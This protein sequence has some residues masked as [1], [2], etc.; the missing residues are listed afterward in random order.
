MTDAE[1]IARLPV[2]VEAPF[3]VCRL[4]V[5]EVHRFG[6][7]V[8][9]RHLSHGFA[10]LIGVSIDSERPIV[11][12]GDDDR[13][14]ARAITGEKPYAVLGMH[15]TSPVVGPG[16]SMVRKDWV[17]T[18]WLRLARHLRDRMGL[19]V[20]AAG[21]ATEQAVPSR[22][23]RNL[24]GLPIKVVGALMEQA[25]CTITVESGLAHLGHAV[26][27]PMVV[28]FS[29]DVPLEWASPSEASRCRV[30][31]ETPRFVTPDDVVAAIHTVLDTK[32]EREMSLAHTR[33]RK[34]TAPRCCGSGRRMRP[35]RA[36]ST[37]STRTRSCASAA[38]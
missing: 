33:Y 26:D 24:Y 23:W 38:M 5:H 16:W 30:L 31:Y 8:F 34:A 17:F 14:A 7:D 11:A 4:D 22:Y 32:L 2:G 19:E 3:R 15:S 10:R 18:R 35:P 21:G 36:S 27:A 29:R 37:T 6:P 20:L 1:W 9:N 13:A 12:I 25:T 28:I